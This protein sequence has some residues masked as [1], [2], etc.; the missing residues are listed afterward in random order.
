[1]MSLI[2]VVPAAVALLAASVFNSLGKVSLFLIAALMLPA[3]VFLTGLCFIAYLLITPID[4]TNDGGVGFAFIF[5]VAVT[6]VGPAVLVLPGMVSGWSA[7][8]ILRLIGRRFEH[9]RPASIDQ[10]SPD[11]L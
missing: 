8:L 7:L 1:M 3:V 4:P 5:I 9:R 11:G 2:F 6:A 10:S